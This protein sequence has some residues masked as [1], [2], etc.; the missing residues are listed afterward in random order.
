MA[1]QEHREFL[2]KRAGALSLREI[3][4]NKQVIEGNIKYWEKNNNPSAVADFK[5]E[6]SWYKERE[7]YLLSFLSDDE[8]RNYEIYGDRLERQRHYKPADYK[9]RLKLT[10]SQSP[11]PNFTKLR[12]LAEEH[13]GHLSATETVLELDDEKCGYTKNP[14][15]GAT[16]EFVSESYRDTF[17][18]QIKKEDLEILKIEEYRNE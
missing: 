3:P 8:K 15:L 17:L 14:A 7:N 5:D 11:Q 13:D 12:G 16:F 18:A 2:R 1:D 10:L 9:F 4:S 6:L